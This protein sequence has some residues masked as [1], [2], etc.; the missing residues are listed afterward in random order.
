MRLKIVTLYVFFLCLMTGCTWIQSDRQSV[1]VLLVEGL[2]AGDFT[3]DETSNFDGGFQRMC[4][5]GIRFS[6]AFTPSTMSQASL[7]SLLTARYPEEH[8]VRHNGVA[9]LVAGF[10]TLAE[11]A[12]SNGYRTAFFSGGPPILRRN[13]LQQGFE[14][15]DDYVQEIQLYPYRDASST[16]AG[17]ER[18][19]DNESRSQPSLTFAYL[20]DI[21]FPSVQ[22]TDSL[23]EPRAR[24]RGSQIEEVNES[25]AKFFR[26]MKQSGHWDKTMVV[27]AG[28]NANNATFR[29]GQTESLNLFSDKTHIALIIKPPQSSTNRSNVKSIDQNVSLVDVG[30]TLFDFIDGK[31]PLVSRRKLDVSSLLPAFSEGNQ[32]WGGDRQVLSETGWPRWR[33]IGPVTQVLR[34]GPY[35]VTGADE[36]NVYDTLKDRSE[37]IRMDLESPDRQQ[38]LDRASQLKSFSSLDVQNPGTLEKLEFARQLWSGR[39]LDTKTFRALHQLSKKYPEDQQLKQWQARVALESRY[40]S[41]LDRLGKLYSQPLWRYV[42]RQHLGQPFRLSGEGCEKAFYR[43]DSPKE[44]FTLRDCND[45]EVVALAQWMNASRPRED[46]DRAREKFIRLFR[47]SQWESHLNRLNLRFGSVWDTRIDLFQGPTHSELLLSL[48]QNRRY[49]AIVEKRVPFNFIQ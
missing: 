27:L 39:D 33:G 41:E 16:L 36:K 23:G 14:A 10:E 46:R 31:V 12:L 45:P 49:V 35:L 28:M 29:P 38:I 9:P 18:W 11:K 1:V 43:D 34:L 2:G 26:W 19:I 3:C 48:P 6:H 25:L 47:A 4:D 44:R 15:F 7:A 20:A 13:G 37:M 17:L 8:L 5:E 32:F 21:Q 42:A 40:W 22:T 24:T 30:A